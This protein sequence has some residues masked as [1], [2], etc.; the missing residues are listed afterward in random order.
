MDRRRRRSGAWGG[1]ALRGA[2][3]HPALSVHASSWFILVPV[4][5]SDAG[6]SWALWVL[7]SLFPPHPSR[8]RPGLASTEHP[9]GRGGA[10]WGERLPAP[11]SDAHLLSPGAAGWLR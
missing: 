11:F 3:L 8:G 7:S 6:P 5:E 4:L 9:E 2:A 1:R 10:P